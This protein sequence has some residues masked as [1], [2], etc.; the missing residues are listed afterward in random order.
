MSEEELRRLN[1]LLDRYYHLLKLAS[2]PLVEEAYWKCV[3]AGVQPDVK[4]WP[5]DEEK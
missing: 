2:L 4:P 1:A 3:D 5:G